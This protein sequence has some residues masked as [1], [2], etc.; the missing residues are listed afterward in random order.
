MNITKNWKLC[1]FQILD[2]GFYNLRMLF[3]V[4]ESVQKRANNAD[5]SRGELHP[6]STWSADII[7]H[8]KPKKAEHEKLVK[9]KNKS[10]VN[11]IS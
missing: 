7:C 9:M 4:L 2:L 11:V 10:E 3:A 8:G 1:I 5:N 6:A